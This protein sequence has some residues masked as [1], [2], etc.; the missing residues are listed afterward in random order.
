MKKC[1]HDKTH[2]ESWPDGGE[3]EVCDI[4][5]MSRHHTE[6]DT[7]EWVMIEDING[8]RRELQEAIDKM[9]PPTKRTK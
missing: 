8:C 6:V 2:Y 3:I 9:G 4:C 7:T 1:I 5:K